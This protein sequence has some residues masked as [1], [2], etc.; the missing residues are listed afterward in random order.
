VQP[1]T[2]FGHE[3]REH[4]ARCFDYRYFYLARSATMS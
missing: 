1:R 3:R 2:I 4:Q